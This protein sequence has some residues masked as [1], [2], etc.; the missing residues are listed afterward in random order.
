MAPRRRDGRPQDRH[1]RRAAGG[2]SLPQSAPVPT[3][4]GSAGG[5]GRAADACRVLA[6]SCRGARAPRR[7]RAPPRARIDRRRRSCG[8]LP[9]P[10]GRS[11]WASSAPVPGRPLPPPRSR[12]TTSAPGARTSGPSMSWKCSAGRRLAPADQ[13]RYWGRSDACLLRP[14]SAQPVRNCGFCQGLMSAKCERAIL[15]RAGSFG[16]SLR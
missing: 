5:G 16:R 10:G 12:A 6:R 3:G 8:S 9:R 15:A 13:R 11:A 7:T 2:R 1:C 14:S 4:A